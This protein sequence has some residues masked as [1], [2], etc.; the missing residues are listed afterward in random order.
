MTAPVVVAGM[1]EAERDAAV[2]ELAQDHQFDTA[3]ELIAEWI[4]WDWHGRFE[5]LD[6][7]IA[8]HPV[9]TA[10]GAVK[11]RPTVKDRMLA[12]FGGITGDEDE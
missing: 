12:E 5:D 3:A 1:T 2:L 10:I 9:N 11:T 8:E 4:I 7:E 6:A